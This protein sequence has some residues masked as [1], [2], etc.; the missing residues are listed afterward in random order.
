MNNEELF[1][2]IYLALRNA[3]ATDKTV[4]G[5]AALRLMMINTFGEED[6]RAFVSQWNEL[7]PQPDAIS[8][9]VIPP[10]VRFLTDRGIELLWIEAG[11]PKDIAQRL[12]HLYS[13]MYERAFGIEDE[14]EQD[15]IQECLARNPPDFSNARILA[16]KMIA[17]AMLTNDVHSIL[18]RSQIALDILQ[19][20]KCQEEDWGRDYEI[21]ETS[22]IATHAMEISH[23]SVHVREQLDLALRLDQ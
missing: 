19:Q 16:N 11:M 5:I 7:Q 20:W 3:P 1:R 13:T 10:S 12:D 2:A 9:F 4:R 14:D 23:W 21:E 8:S 17:T 18:E 22:W 6:Q 15:A